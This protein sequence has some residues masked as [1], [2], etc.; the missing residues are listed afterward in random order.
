MARI[1]VIEPDGD[2][3]RL[4]GLQ[5]GRL[6]HEAVVGEFDGLTE[7][8]PFDV[9]LIEPAHAHTAT[10]ARLLA[11]KRPELPLVFVSMREP[12]PETAALRPVAHLVKPVR[13]TE[14]GRALALALAPRAAPGC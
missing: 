10:C 6:G 7:E 12:M 4:L 14:L 5:L 2:I 13:L 9:A 1:L 8:T 11:L 3:R